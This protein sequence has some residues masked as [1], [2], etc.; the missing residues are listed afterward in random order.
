[1]HLYLTHTLKTASIIQEGG[2]LKKKISFITHLN[3][4][5]HFSGVDVFACLG[6][7]LVEADFMVLKSTITDSN[8]T[9]KV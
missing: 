3:F 9:I 5:L 8:F 2:Y 6:A 1:M 7:W 4:H